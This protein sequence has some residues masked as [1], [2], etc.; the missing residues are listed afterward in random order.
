M[1]L[2]LTKYIAVLLVFLQATV[3]MITPGRVLCLPVA[4][5]D[6]QEFAATGCQDRSEAGQHDDLD[7][8]HDPAAPGLAPD[9]LN[10]CGCHLHVPIPGDPKTPGQSQA[11][12]D[13]FQA[14]QSVIPVVVAVLQ[15]DWTPSIGKSL[16]QR[17][18]DPLVRG[19]VLSLKTTRLRI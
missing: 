11:R 3:G 15:W 1:T 8:D 17:P 6:H 18:V 13:G 5:C 14:R 19:L 9:H 10:E 2:S 16:S 4:D 7:C 12:G